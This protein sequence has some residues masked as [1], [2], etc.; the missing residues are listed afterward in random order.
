MNEPIRKAIA[1]DFDGCLCSYA[2]PEIG[3]PHWDVISRAK[4]EQQMGAGLIL[5]TCREG[6]LLQEAIDAC[7]MWNL[8]F[9]AV[10]ESLPEWIEAYGNNPRKVGATEYWDD[11]AVAVCEG[12]LCHKTLS[13]LAS[14]FKNDPFALVWHAF[15][16]LY[17]DEQFEAYWEPAI[18][19]SEDGTP[20]LGLTDFCDGEITAVF[21]S[22]SLE[23]GHAVVIFAH[24]LAHVA[25][26]VDHEHDDAWKDAF[27]AIFREYNHIASALLVEE[28]DS[29]AN[30]RK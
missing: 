12:Y 8:E 2:F 17:P 16:K 30:E 1:I 23:V 14:P 26:G 18:R 28:S 29:G 20:V 25:V 21:V 3:A 7:T 10:N 6:D 13:G 15:T 22:S 5:W 4:K 9:D 11:R 27:D 19:E 24:E